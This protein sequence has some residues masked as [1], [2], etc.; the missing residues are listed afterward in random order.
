MPL[1]SEYATQVRVVSDIEYSE[2]VHL[3]AQ[4][5][6]VI[7][8]RLRRRL[9]LQRGDTLIARSE[10]GRLVVEKAEVT[11]QRLK[12]RYARVP[13]NRSLAKELLAE[14]REEAKRESGR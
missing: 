10:H 3:G 2:E 12:A 1:S 14:R 11:K 6:L 8:A 4:G 7:P 5:R 9:G 13:G